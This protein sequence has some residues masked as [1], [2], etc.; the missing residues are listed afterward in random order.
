MTKNRVVYTKGFKLAI[1]SQI[2]SELPLAQV[3]R[4]NGLHPALVSRW[5]KYRRTVLAFQEWGDID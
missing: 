2:E 4:E 5:K 3:A 1:L